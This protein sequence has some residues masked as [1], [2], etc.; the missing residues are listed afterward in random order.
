M[1]QEIT[2]LWFRQDL[3]LKDNP[4]LQAAIQTGN[5]ILPLYI[6][7]EDIGEEWK[8]GSASKVWL[9]SSLASLKESLQAISSDLYIR[10]GDTTQII[11]ALC[12]KLPIKFVFWNRL[13]EPFHIKR[14]TELKKN[15]KTY[16]I[17]TESFNASLLFEPWTVQNKQEKP[18]RVFSQFW[19]TC[20]Q[21]PSPPQPIEAPLNMNR[22][23]LPADTLNIRDLNLL[24]RNPDWS[25]T[26]QTEWSPGEKGALQ[27]WQEFLYGNII[28]YDKGRDIPGEEYT[29]KLSPHL[30]FGEI[31]PRQIWWDVE[32]LTKKD[33]NHARYM[34]E[35]G[36]REFS[37]HLLYHFSE[38]PDQSI[39]TEFES[40]PWIS[41]SDADYEPFLTAW[42]KGQ[43]GYPIVDAGMRELWATGWMHNRVRMIVAS[44]LIKDLF[45]HW[46]K[47]EDWFWDCLVDADLAN[48][49]A[50]WQWVAGSGFDASPYFRIFNPITQ[51]EKFDPRG[52]YIRKWVPELK[53]L[54][55]QY[56]HKPWEAGPITLKQAN[57][58]LGKTYPEPIVNHKRAREAALAAYQEMKS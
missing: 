15:L 51:G 13:Y 50:S 56:I 26:M 54:S 32:A 37:Y 28:Y 42:Q 12:Q 52:D 11:E 48:N 34:S 43:T 31:S 44:F 46:K 58:D 41:E 16:D 45:I 27:R 39:K 38:L 22:A 40:F 25:Q 33:K 2:L 7:D 49:A 9:H 5:P 8:M 19:K 4:A 35:I 17:N 30:H 18:Y 57:I 29:S 24:P 21:Y 53:D 6:Y 20:L 47:G 1:T 3:R 14:D 36:W 10:S 55:Q 23:E